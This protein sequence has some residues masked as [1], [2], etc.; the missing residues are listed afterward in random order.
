MSLPPSWPRNQKK[1]ADLANAVAQWRSLEAALRSKDTEFTRVLG[2]NK[3]L[4]SDVAEL[5]EQL[6]N[7]G[8][9]MLA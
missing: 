3:T 4:T 5:Q 8:D 2:D 6:D 7:V 9:H 1:E